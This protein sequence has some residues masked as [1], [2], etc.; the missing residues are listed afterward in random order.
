MLQ[1]LVQGLKNKE[2]AASLFISEG[3]IKVYLS[4]L[5]NKLGVKDRFE[6]ALGGSLAAYVK[7]RAAG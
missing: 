5:F 4:R 1:L 2:I 6:L 7:E 3:T